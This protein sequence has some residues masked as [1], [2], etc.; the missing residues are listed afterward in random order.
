MKSRDFS[1]RAVSG[2]CG[3]GFFWGVR[4]IL[5]LGVAPSSE[6]LPHAQIQVDL[7]PSTFSLDNPTSQ[8]PSKENQEW[9]PK[10]S[11][12][13]ISVFLYF[14]EFLCFTNISV[15]YKW[16]CLNSS[17]QHIPAPGGTSTNSQINNISPIYLQEPLLKCTLIITILPQCPFPL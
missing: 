3:L 10:S 7:F 11:H 2:F 16:D 5:G 12:P 6:N 8:G 15:F 9:F 4:E 1:G 17:S 14:T 13:H